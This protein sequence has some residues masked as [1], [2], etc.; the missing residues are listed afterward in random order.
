[1]EEGGAGGGVGE[2]RLDQLEVANADRIELQMLGALVVAQ[3][4]DVR[5]IAC[6][7]GADIVQCGAGGDGGCGMAGEAEAIE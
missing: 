2:E 5:K 7:R 3:A 1:M 4:V 6:L